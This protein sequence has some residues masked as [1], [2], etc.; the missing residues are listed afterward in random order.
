MLNSEHALWAKLYAVSANSTGD[1]SFGHVAL[2]KD[3]Q[4]FLCIVSQTLMWMQGNQWALATLSSCFQR[5]TQQT[6]CT[7]I[8]VYYAKATRLEDEDHTYTK[9]VTEVLTKKFT[10]QFRKGYSNR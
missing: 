1:L 10:P 8:P 7:K 6:I 5:S 4:V 2:I 3:H 9:T